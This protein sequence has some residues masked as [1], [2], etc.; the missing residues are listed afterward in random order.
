MTGRQPRFRKA[1]PGRTIQIDKRSSTIRR[2][3]NPNLT[4][5]P[6]IQQA[7]AVHEARNGVNDIG[8]SR[9][10]LKSVGRARVQGAEGG[11]LYSGR[12]LSGGE[13]WSRREDVFD[14]ARFGRCPAGCRTRQAG[15]LFHPDRGNAAVNGSLISTGGGIGPDGFLTGRGGE[16]IFGRFAVVRAV[17]RKEARVL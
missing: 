15:S 4:Q 2:P 8:I 10:T 14:R 11:I 5:R 12:D 9:R 1:I 13:P 3:K 6:Q 7:Q 16:A 17:A